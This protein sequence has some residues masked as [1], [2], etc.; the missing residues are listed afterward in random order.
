MPRSHHAA[1][2]P[3]VDVPDLPPPTFDARRADYLIFLATWSPV[4]RP[5]HPTHC[6]LC[7]ATIT[8]SDLSFKDTRSHLCD[9][10]A[11]W[12]CIFAIT[13]E[14]LDIHHALAA[15]PSPWARCP[16]LPPALRTR[17]YGPEP[18]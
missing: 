15:L 4:T 18:T 11:C 12:R 2:R 3:P 14:R 16:R 17:R 7:G 1:P 13:C 8:L 5:P 9:T 10:Y 6:D